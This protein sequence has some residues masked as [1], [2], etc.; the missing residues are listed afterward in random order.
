MGC[1]LRGEHLEEGKS[2]MKIDFTAKG[3]TPSH[4]NKQHSTE[5]LLDRVVHGFN[6]SFKASLS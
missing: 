4:L 5:M 1:C 2:P 6:Y 3:E